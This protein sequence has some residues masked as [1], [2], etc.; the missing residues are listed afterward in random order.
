MQNK[1]R[2]F[3]AAA[4]VAATLLL[5]CGAQEEPVTPETTTPSLYDFTG[6]DLSV[7]EYALFCKE[8]PGAEIIWDIP[9]QGKRYSMDT[10]ELTL[11]G[12]TQEEAQT[13]TLFPH[14][15]RI[16]ASECTKLESLLLLKKSLPQ[17]QLIYQVPLGGA[18]YPSGTEELTLADVPAQEIADA[19]P[20]LDQVKTV[21]ISGLSDSEIKT[22]AERFQNVFFCCELPFCGQR[23][24]TDSRE[25]DLSG[26]P[27]TVREVEEALPFFPKLE[28]L[29][30][31]DCGLDDEEL[32][33][34]NRAHPQTQIV[35]TLMIGRTKMR[36][37]DTIFY[38]SKMGESNLPHNEELKK[39]RY[40]TELV[41][42][43]IGHS[44]ATE[45]EWL[46][47]LPHVKYL[48]LA[49]T[50][51]GDLTP[52][53]NLK[54]LVYLEVFSLPIS[55]Y[56]PLLGCTA[57]QDLNI[58]GTHGDPAP[59][60]QMTWLH[61]LQWYQGADDPETREAVLLLEEQLPDTNIVIDT[62]R[63]VG[64]LWRYLPHYYIF[65]DYIGGNFYNQEY[66]TQYWG[67][68]DATKIYACDGKPRYAGDT[69]AEIIKERMEQGLPIPGIKNVGS[70]KEE[71]LYRSLLTPQS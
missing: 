36:T 28:K 46:E 7:E 50:N 33:A 6:Q 21:T 61:N 23:F 41:A 68:K 43:D 18:V 15:N 63:N 69:L 62:F 20:L 39:L 2:I 56:T 30:L 1:K 51:I 8:H 38:P 65:R 58:S 27:L 53:S 64:G 70:E 5:G 34:L 4:G 35:W 55:D 17:C 13:L 26:T 66:I 24:S 42:L 11:S 48:I 19:L 25:I 57:L 47:Y 60:S 45:C 9:F 59:L 32:D 40:C 37:D 44:D 31:S 14:L 10:E 52:L 71:I 67:T 49:D 16:D 12:L 22:L 3:L 54:E 29:I